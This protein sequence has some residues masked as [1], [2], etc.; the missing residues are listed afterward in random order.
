MPTFVQARRSRLL[1]GGFRT[2]GFGQAI[3][4][5]PTKTIAED[6][7]WRK[8]GSPKRRGSM[9]LIS[10][11]IIGLLAG[12][13]LPA[14]GLLRSYRRGAKERSAHL[15][16]LAE[17]EAGPYPGIE[18]PPLKEIDGGDP[19]RVAFHCLVRAAL[20]WGIDKNSYALGPQTISDDRITYYVPSS[21]YEHAYDYLRRVN[22]LEEGPNRDHQLVCSLPQ[23]GSATDA[24]YARGID[25]ETAFEEMI[26]VISEAGWLDI[27]EDNTILIH[28]R[29]SVREIPVPQREIDDILAFMHGLTGLNFAAAISD[30]YGPSFRLTSRGIDLFKKAYLYPDG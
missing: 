29:K 22:L 17:R 23:L 19:E 27:L 1:W 6:L 13:V 9:S 12:A 11:S 30:N 21:S 15:A 4:A 26:W 3:L 16:S 25:F 2:V 10:W 8:M 24:A 7:I 14:I 28:R 18:I 5:K 20:V